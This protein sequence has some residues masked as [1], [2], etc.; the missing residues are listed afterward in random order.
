ME[1]PRILLADDDAALRESVQKLLESEFRIVASVGDGQALLE[2]AQA[3]T[4]DL[5]IADISMPFLDGFQ[6]IRRLKAIQ[7]NARI[8]FLTV[9]DE[10]PFVAEAMKIGASGYVVKRFAHL[11]LVPAVRE[12]LRGGSF[13]S[14]TARE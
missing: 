10:R 6:A 1:K 14:A 11:D 3:L 12:A 7:P 9:H 5:I 13:I 8:I 2:A 4:P